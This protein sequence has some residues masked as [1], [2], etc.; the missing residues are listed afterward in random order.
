MIKPDAY[1][2]IGKIL[3]DVEESGFE[4]T[5]LKMARFTDDN[6]FGFYGAEHGDKAFFPDLVKFM[7][8]GY[9]VGMELTDPKGDAITKWRTLIGPTD[10]NVRSL[11]L[12]MP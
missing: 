9:V 10:S 8:S 3:T 6:A 7:T 4:L 11:S 5:N 12:C 2:H 1:K